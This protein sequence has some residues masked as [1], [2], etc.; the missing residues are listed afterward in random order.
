MSYS[1]SAP[2]MEVTAASVSF[3]CLGTIGS[4]V[5]ERMLDHLTTCQTNNK[6][7]ISSVSLIFNRDV[8]EYMGQI[9]I[10]I[11]THEQ[12]TNYSRGWERVLELVKE[13]E[14][15]K[16]DAVK[17]SPDFFFFFFLYLF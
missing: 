1:L 12:G 5:C 14:V 9:K 13:R 15:V 2:A 8:V 4:P 16:R 17:V 11:L 3:D 7:V 6:S 10:Q